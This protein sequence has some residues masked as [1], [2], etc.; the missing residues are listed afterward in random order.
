MKKHSK[1]TGISLVE[2]LLSLAIF[3]L[4]IVGLY[5]S[6]QAMNKNLQLSAQR[7]LEA[8][9]ANQLINEVNPTRV[10]VETFYDTTG[11]TKQSI[12]LPD[13]RT[14]W[15]LRQVTS[16]AATGD[17]K[18]V[19]IYFFHKQSDA[20]TAPYRHFKRDI[21]LQRICYNMTWS[22]MVSPPQYQTYRDSAGQVWTLLDNWPYYSAT[23]SARRAGVVFADVASDPDVINYSSP[24]QDA[25]GVIDQYAW[26]TVHSVDDGSGNG[27]LSYR[28]PASIGQGYK[29]DL[30][31]REYEGG[32]FVSSDIV[33]ID[34]NG[35]VVDTA[36][37][38]FTEA[39]GVSTGAL[40][41][42]GVIESYTTTGI[43]DGSG[44]GIINVKVINN[45]SANFYR[46]SVAWICLTR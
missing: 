10:D 40:S 18:E 38:I 3:S 45:G 26:Q 33:N 20:S 23:S 5:L 2:I 32:A 9:Y 39:G 11:T 17:I 36:L 25:V 1:Q 37:D 31:L 43:N 15:Y 42:G 22:G 21:L 41:K 16:Q 30:G 8:A 19:N 35:T 4:G 7:D 12:S 34:I 29:V 28:F 6:I 27:V 46:P 24:A 13:G 14:V 44:N